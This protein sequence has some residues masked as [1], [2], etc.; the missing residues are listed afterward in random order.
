VHSAF[1]ILAYGLLYSSII[2]LVVRYRTHP[3]LGFLRSGPLY[4]LGIISYS[5]YLCHYPI[6]SEYQ[7]LASSNGLTRSL[8]SDLAIAI[9]CLVVAIPLGDIAGRVTDL[10][11]KSAL[12][13][14]TRPS[15]YLR[16][17]IC[18]VT[19]TTRTRRSHHSD[20]GSRHRADGGRHGPAS[21]QP[22]S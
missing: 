19:A 9:L 11:Y 14:A 3:C 5:F 20:A 16:K 2:G 18:W 21:R 6:V 1:V 8:A 17:A 22:P 15:C 10:P 13:S 4:G 7:I 12:R